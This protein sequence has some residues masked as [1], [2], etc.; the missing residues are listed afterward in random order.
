[1]KAINNIIDMP[2]V[3]L[4]KEAARLLDE[5]AKRLRRESS[6]RIVKSDIIYDA[7]KEYAKKLEVDVE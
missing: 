7:L 6:I 1:V 5:L 2:M 4:S 3:Y